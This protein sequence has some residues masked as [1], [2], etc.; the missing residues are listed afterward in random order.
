MPFISSNL[1]TVGTALTPGPGDNLVIGA[2]VSVTSLT[3]SA[4]FASGHLTLTLLPGAAVASLGQ[5]VTAVDINTLQADRGSPGLAWPFPP[6]IVVSDGAA[7]YSACGS[8]LHLWNG[9]AAP[10]ALTNAGTIIG[11]H[12]TVRLEGFH[13]N[14][15]NSGRIIGVLEVE[16]GAHIVNFGFIDGFVRQTRG[17]AEIINR[18]VITESVW[19]A[20]GSVFDGRFGEVLG[21]HYGSSGSETFLIDQD[22]AVLSAGD[23][24]DIAHIWG[25]DMQI[26][27]VERVIMRGT[28]AIDLEGSEGG[29]HIRGNRADNLLTG[30]TAGDDTLFGMGGNDTLEGGTGLDR[31]AGGTAMT[32]WQAGP[33]PPL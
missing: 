14:A 18:G 21:G 13:I 25:T 32:V 24:D 16:F 22:G 17:H 8:A 28:R 2:G 7:I 30:G 1:V 3:S 6:Q 27:G 12:E 23:G 9:F 19:I 4:I 29:D 33:E 10:A 15:D 5:D 20:S 11:A 26:E 31:L